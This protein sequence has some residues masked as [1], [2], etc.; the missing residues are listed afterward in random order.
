MQQDDFG[1]LYKKEIEGDE[2]LVMVG[3]KFLPDPMEP[4]GLFLRVPPDVETAASSGLD[5]RD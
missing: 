4:S 5:F 3:R 1:T 2:A